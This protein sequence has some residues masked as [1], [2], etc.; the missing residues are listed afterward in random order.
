MRMHTV[1]AGECL[2][3]IAHQY[4]VPWRKVYEHP[5]NAEF[6]KLRP[7][8]NVI[9]ES[10]RVVIPDRDEKTV[11]AATGRTHRFVV[12]KPPKWVFRLAMKDDEGNPIAGIPFELQMTGHATASGKTKA[13]GLIEIPIPAHVR[14][15]TLRF[16]G[17]IFAVHFGMLDP[18]WRVKGI[19]ARLNNLGFNAGA[20]DGIVGARTRKAIYA[21]QRAHADLQATGEIDD[22]TRRLLLEMH[23][24]DKNL[25]APEESME[26]Q[27]AGEAAADGPPEQDPAPEAAA[28]GDD[29]EF[30]DWTADTVAYG[31]V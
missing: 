31:G 25:R 17:E 20:V 16:L 19:Q 15:G 8:P 9:Y 4:G 18:V 24:N 14:E 29:E 26:F 10:D 28:G 5:D 27:A 11:F 7:N 1:R 30:P 21:F 12:L 2:A 6:R 23:D 3:S 22:A 13:D